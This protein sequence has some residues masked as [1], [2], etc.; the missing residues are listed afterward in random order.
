MQN[1]YRA[2]DNEKT[3]VSVGLGHVFAYM[4]G[5]LALTALVSCIT[6][7][8]VENVMERTAFL[9]QYFTPVLIIS[10]IGVVILMLLSRLFARKNKFVGSIIVFALYSTFMGFLISPLMIMFDSL[11]IGSVFAGTAA[12]FGTMALYGAL[13]KRN[14]MGIGMFASG[15]AVGVIILSLINLFVWKE[16]IYYLIIF[17]GLASMLGYTA[18]DVNVARRL[19][20]SGEL[21]NALSIYMAIQIYTDFIYIFLRIAMLFA[22]KKD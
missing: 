21:T 18:F 12:S 2:N 4:F 22:R 14:T 8:I 6:A 3:R 9:N 10:S 5:G 19:A 1:I 20:D 7:I 17:L 13:T 11:F 16:S 15:L